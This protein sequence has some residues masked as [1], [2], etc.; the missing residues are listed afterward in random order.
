MYI[1][2]EVIIIFS[3]EEKKK[4]T[5]VIPLSWVSLYLRILYVIS[6]FI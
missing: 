6:A 5:P 3:L 1:Y 4:H 2:V